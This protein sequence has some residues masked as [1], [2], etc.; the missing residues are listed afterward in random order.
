MIER[1]SFER[2]LQDLGLRE[3]EANQYEVALGAPSSNRSSRD[4]IRWIQNA[5]NR[6]IGLRLTVDGRMG[7]HTQSAIKRFQQRHRLDANGKID[8][9]TEA[10][11]INESANP[12]KR[13]AILGR[14]IA[15]P[16]QFYCESYAETIDRFRFDQSG[17]VRDQAN[18][19]D[20]FSIIDKLA[21]RVTASWSTSRP[22]LVVCL[23]GHTDTRGSSDYNYKLGIRRAESVKS[24]LQNAIMRE[25][26]K[27]QRPD[28]P[29]KIQYG[30]NSIGE[31]SPIADNLTEDG[32]SR[33]RRVE[34]YFS[35]G[36][37]Q[38]TGSKHTPR[39]PRCG[40]S[41]NILQS[42]KKQNLQQELIPLAE[43]EANSRKGSPKLCLYQ[44]ADYATAL[45][46]AQANRWARQIRA[47][48]VSPCAN[49]QIGA[50]PYKDGFG[51]L[52]ALYDAFKCSGNIPLKEVH[53]FGH[54]FEEGLIGSTPDFVGLYRDITVHYR[55]REDKN[56]Y[57]VEL[58]SPWPGKTDTPIALGAR[59]I[60]DI[61]TSVLAQDVV[62]ILHGCNT[63]NTDP[64]WVVNNIGK[65]FAESL[66]DYLSGDLRDPKVYGHYVS[67][68]SGQDS[69]W[70]GYIYDWSKGI[71]SKK[72]TTTSS[73]PYYSG[74]GFC[75]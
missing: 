28:I 57:K 10:A 72:M 41:Q 3:F 46:M 71:K 67:T 26:I 73:I 21:K 8:A 19:I 75:S 59:L 25:A 66:F 16:M 20:H 54:M 24:G 60:K 13:D 17:L 55:S 1:L 52:L 31:L 44:D 70:R 65:N 64:K 53:I 7:P 63:A 29:M 39:E 15:M 9:K 40:A 37:A 35:T 62:F 61:P 74:N 49:S 69:Y 42:L 4:Y 34:V 6:V 45:F 30:V 36:T 2:E 58:N 33:N 23:D 14:T 32:R 68:C 43:L 48:K 51:I 5:L 22:I 47:V 12:K 11:L 38:P 27:A 56:I 50:T 18:R